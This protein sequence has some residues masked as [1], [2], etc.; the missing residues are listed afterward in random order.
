[1]II[2]II[3]AEFISK[4]FAEIVVV[5]RHKNIENEDGLLD[6]LKKIMLEI[7][8]SSVIYCHF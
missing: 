4:S 3:D 6:V 5:E 1:M 8:K 2:K 7:I